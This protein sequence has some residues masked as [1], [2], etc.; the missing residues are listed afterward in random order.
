MT[1]PENK[2]LGSHCYDTDQKPIFDQKPFADFCAGPSGVNETN[3]PGL[4]SQSATPQSQINY[5]GYSTSINGNLNPYFYSFGNM[6]YPT[7]NPTPQSTSFHY[8]Q[9]ST[10]PESENRHNYSLLRFRL[11][12]RNSDKDHRGDR[13]AHQL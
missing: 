1:S 5:S 6:P 3:I 2:Q 13:S 8:P 7:N 4:S 9:T 10:S 11:Y 12:K